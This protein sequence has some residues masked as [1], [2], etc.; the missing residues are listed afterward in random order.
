MFI[1]MITAL[2]IHNWYI[3]VYQYGIISIILDGTNIYNCRTFQL[4]SIYTTNCIVFTCVCD[5]L[6][7][8]NTQSAVW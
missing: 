7:T 1:E 6:V 8:T 5:L 2:L 3:Q 4:H